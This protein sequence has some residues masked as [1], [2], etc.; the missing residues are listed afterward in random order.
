MHQKASPRGKSLEPADGPEASILIQGEEDD[1][2]KGLVQPQLEA[3]EERG[4]HKGEAP[5]QGHH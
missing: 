3:V 5:G 2:R 4:Q 1:P